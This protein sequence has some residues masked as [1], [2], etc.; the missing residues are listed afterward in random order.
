MVFRCFDTGPGG[1]RVFFWFA[2]LVAGA[3]QG[4]G[5]LSSLHGTRPCSQWGRR[6]KHFGGAATHAC[7]QLA[8]QRGKPLLFNM[9]ETSIPY[10]VQSAPGIVKGGFTGQINIRP[11]DRRHPLFL[12]TV[13][14]APSVRHSMPS[15]L[16]C[17]THRLSVRL[18]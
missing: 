11:E 13:C 8:S 7:S 18:A 16:L 17:S 2:F 5:P 1:W 14:S 4:F 9:D 12:L 6:R 10:A 15:F 3:P